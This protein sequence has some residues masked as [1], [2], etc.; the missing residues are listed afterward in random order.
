MCEMCVDLFVGILALLQKHV[1][2]V[3]R[4]VGV[5]VG[6]RV[7]GEVVHHHR[8]TLELPLEDIN[9]VQEQDERGQL[10]QLV[11]RDRVEQGHALH[12]PVQALVVLAGLVVCRECNHED[13]GVDIV[14]VWTIS[15]I[16]I[17]KEGGEYLTKCVCLWWVWFSQN[18]F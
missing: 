15:I 5:V 8:S 9:L 17:G 1:L 4:C 2:N 6:P 10:K 7:I 16:S 12:K 3:C 11:V 18:D 14:K 13:D